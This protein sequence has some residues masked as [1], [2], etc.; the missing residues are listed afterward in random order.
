[1][2]LYFVK[3]Y[4]RWESSKGVI[5]LEIF[6]SSVIY[7]KLLLHLEI[8]AALQYNLFIVF[9]ANGS[10]DVIYSF[11]DPTRNRDH[12]ILASFATPKSCNHHSSLQF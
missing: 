3:R 11:I 8:A 4:D 5:S 1:M 7:V 12:L 10:L 9:G 6:D 2:R